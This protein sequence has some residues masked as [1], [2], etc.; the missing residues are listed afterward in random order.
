[1]IPIN[2]NNTIGSNAV[3]AS[4]IASVI[5]QIAIN[6]IMAAILVTSGLPGSRS[7]NSN[8]HRNT[9]GP[10]H[11][12]MLL[13]GDTTIE[14]IAVDSGGLVIGCLSLLLIDGLEDLV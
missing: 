6:T 5:H 11:R 4:G 10:S 14:S 1:M 3:A 9:N 2:G 12:P 8:M 7:T 13:R